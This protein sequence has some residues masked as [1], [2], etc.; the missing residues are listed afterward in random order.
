MVLHYATGLYYVQGIV[1][2]EDRLMPK[3]GGVDKN[4]KSCSGRKKNQDLPAG[5]LD[6]WRS[7]FIPTW[8]WALGFYD[9]PWVIND[10]DAV[11]I[12]QKIWDV[13]YKGVVSHTIVVN[14]A[15]FAIVS[16][17]KFLDGHTYYI[18][19]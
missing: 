11:V 3:S 17:L 13:V 4:S 7:C 16:V 5:C 18:N 15:V 8:H 14:D 2:I 12:M 1:K 6:L 9:D 10:D 19:V